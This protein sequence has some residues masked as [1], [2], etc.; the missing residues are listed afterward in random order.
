MPM[1]RTM[2][3]V[4]ALF[5]LVLAVAAAAMAVTSGSRWP[6]VVVAG[7]LAALACVTIPI[8]TRRRT[9]ADA[10]PGAP[11]G[12]PGEDRPPE[13]D[14]GLEAAIVAEDG[15]RGGVPGQ[16]A[17]APVIAA[18]LAL[19]GG[20][21]RG[22]PT[23]GDALQAEIERAMVERIRADQV[24]VP[25]YPA[26][27]HRIRELVAR[28]DYGLDEV[29]RLVAADARL[30][31]DT[32]R[33]ANSVLYCRGEPVTSMKAAV[34]RVGSQEVVRVALTSALAGYSRAAGPLLS[35]RRRAWVDSVASAAICEHLARRRGAPSEDG[36]VCGLLHDFGKLVAIACIEEVL[37]SRRHAPRPAAFW[38][39]MVERFH[40]ELGMVSAA[41]WGLPPLLG[42][43][44]AA[45]HAPST[46]GTADARLV[47]IVAAGDGVVATMREQP[48]VT[49][50]H[51]LHSAHVD[52]AEASA[53]EAVVEGVPSFVASFEGG[54][55]TV[56]GSSASSLVAPPRIDAVPIEPL[57]CALGDDHDGLV[58]SVVATC[59]DSLL[60]RSARPVE[61]DSLARL[62]LRC[63][64]SPIACWST[65]RA[66]WREANGADALLLQPVA[67]GAAEHERWREVGR[68]R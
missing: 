57:E 47:A 3:R 10:R 16:S 64:P 33:C 28:H 38:D 53:L 2:A 17:C 1:P 30:A 7:A 46:A 48:R 61:Q 55:L 19:P 21:C 42:D 56:G 12:D 14:A 68:L 18:P 39:E 66:C 6:L 29:A 49:R 45:H 34:A 62:E 43:A 24:T 36:F 32:L 44:I 9:D 54:A 59:G 4:A 25:P 11:D 63:R 52:P 51:L 20:D 40:V 8:A 50:A 60:A 5:G 65:V 35:L 41:R 27:A 23:F 22:R 31:A 58:V 15:V 26:I 13:P 37:A 67:L